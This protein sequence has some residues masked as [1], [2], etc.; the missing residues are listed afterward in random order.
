MT[1]KFKDI[2]E[3]RAYCNSH[4]K[5]KVGRMSNGKFF[6]QCQIGWGQKKLGKP[7]NCEI[8]VVRGGV[9]KNL[10]SENV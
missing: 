1:N 9:E 2:I 7:T 4:L 10:G 6:P 8:I 5:G 3:E